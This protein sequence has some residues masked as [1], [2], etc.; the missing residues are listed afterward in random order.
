MSRTTLIARL[1][2]MDRLDLIKVQQNHD[3]LVDAAAEAA[4]SGRVTVPRTAKMYGVPERTCAPLV[5]SRISRPGVNAATQRSGSFLDREV[6]KLAAKSLITFRIIN[7]PK[8]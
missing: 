6:P 1:K 2:I 3:M 4:K 7:H 8:R 5:P